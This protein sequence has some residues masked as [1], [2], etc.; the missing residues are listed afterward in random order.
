MLPPGLEAALLGLEQAARD[1]SG[2]ID[3]A[4]ADDAD[5]AAYTS[6]RVRSVYHLPVVG[7]DAR[8]NGK[9]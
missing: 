6:L 7:H 9:R 3:K 2:A 1:L 8:P 4:I 5:E